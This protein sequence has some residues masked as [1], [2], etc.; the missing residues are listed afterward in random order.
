MH[1]PPD[2][3]NPYESPRLAEVAWRPN[4]VAVHLVEIG[5]FA[6]VSY[7]MGYLIGPSAD[8]SWLALVIFWL[9]TMAYSIG[10]CSE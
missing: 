8:V 4:R 6:A 5:V 9:M 7:W 2:K 1:A 3:L 10:C